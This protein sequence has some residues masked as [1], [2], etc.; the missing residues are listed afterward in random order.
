MSRD[1]TEYQTTM[2]VSRHTRD[3]SCLDYAEPTRPMIK[4][5]TLNGV[6]HKLHLH[7]NNERNVQNLIHLKDI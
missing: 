5:Y 1:F 2:H 3:D 7:A 6:L 4:A